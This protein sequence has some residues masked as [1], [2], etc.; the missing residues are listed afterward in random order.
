MALKVLRGDSFEE[1][2]DKFIQLHEK[3]CNVKGEDGITSK[4]VVGFTSKCLIESLNF[5]TG[6]P[7]YVQSIEFRISNEKSQM[8][9]VDSSNCICRMLPE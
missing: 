9:D 3:A 7:F 5:Y 8:I 6:A 1:Y 4:I 2:E